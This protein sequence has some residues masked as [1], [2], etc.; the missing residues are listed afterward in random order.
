[1]SCCVDTQSGNLDFFYVL[2]AEIS[3]NIGLQTAVTVSAT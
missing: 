1:M 2:R 3:A